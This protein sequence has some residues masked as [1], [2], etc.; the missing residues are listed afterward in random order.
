LPNRIDLKNHMVQ[1]LFVL[2]QSGLRGVGLY[3][4]HLKSATLLMHRLP[5]IFMIALHAS[6]HVDEWSA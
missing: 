3:V 6:L 2:I 1:I 5:R 4:T